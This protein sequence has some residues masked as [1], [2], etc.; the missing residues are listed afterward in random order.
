[1]VCDSRPS[2]EAAPARVS[3]PNCATVAMNPPVAPATHHR[4]GVS[5]TKSAELN[6][7][8]TERTRAVGSRQR[9]RGSPVPGSSRTS[10]APDSSSE[11]WEPGRFAVADF[12]CSPCGRRSGNSCLRS[13]AERLSPLS[14]T[15]PASEFALPAPRLPLRHRQGPVGRAIRAP[16]RLLA[17]TLGLRRRQV[18]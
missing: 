7:S 4:R 16:L 14:F 10:G 13:E 17:R 12:V 18:L 2:R 3:A 8:M 11:C 15:K 5:V 1:M 9:P 6:S